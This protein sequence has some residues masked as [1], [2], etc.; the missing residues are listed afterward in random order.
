MTLS[1]KRTPVCTQVRSRSQS[2]SPW[3]TYCARF[4]G[5]EVT[6]F[7]G[8]QPL[9]TAV[10][11]VEAIGVKGVNAWDLHV[12]DLCLS[13]LFNLAYTDGET[14]PVKAAPESVEQGGEF[15]LFLAVGK[16]DSLCKDAQV[17]A[18]DDQIELFPDPV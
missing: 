9:L 17:V 14:F 8:Q 7:I 18:T 2:T 5:A 10:V 13:V 6:G 12:K 3:R 16:T 11:D 4:D 15:R 1:R